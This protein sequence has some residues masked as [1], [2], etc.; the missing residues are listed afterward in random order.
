M[1]PHFRPGASVAQGLIEGTGERLGIP[2]Q[3]AFRSIHSL[4]SFLLQII[5]MIYNRFW[6][7]HA[8]LLQNGVFATNRL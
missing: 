3:S 1:E 7:N 2:A 6:V 8:N 5:L 4:G